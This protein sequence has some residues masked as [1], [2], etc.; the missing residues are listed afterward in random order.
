MPV[1]KGQT[2]RTDLYNSPRV[3]VVAILDAGVRELLTWTM[4]ERPGAPPLRLR[5]DPTIGQESSRLP[6]RGGALCTAEDRFGFIQQLLTVL[7]QRAIL[8]G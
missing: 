3:V 5:R 7:M 4:A 8:S 2:A 6:A 1:P